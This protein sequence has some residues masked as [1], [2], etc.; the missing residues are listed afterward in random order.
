MNW[1]CHRGNDLLG[2][3]NF[4]IKVWIL[5]AL[6]WRQCI[7]I[8]II[9]C[10]LLALALGLHH[11]FWCCCDIAKRENLMWL[12]IKFLR[13]KLRDDS[14]WFFI[15]FYVKSCILLNYLVWGRDM[16]YIIGQVTSYR[17]CVY[18]SSGIYLSL[19]MHGKHS[20][21]IFTHFTR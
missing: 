15:H 13:P 6:E 11:L 2:W 12:K 9:D 21:F 19:V 5:R 20:S 10:N 17:L 16:K 3:L 7:I 4:V 1:L 18:I 14:N 8:I